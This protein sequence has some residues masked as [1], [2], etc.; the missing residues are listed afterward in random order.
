V[1]WKISYVDNG[2]AA[3]WATDGAPASAEEVWRR[4]GGGDA[5]RVGRLMPWLKRRKKECS[6]EEI[7]KRKNRHEGDF[8][9]VLEARTGVEPV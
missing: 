2:G 9:C 6:K 8:F 4:D 5:A 3:V 7:Q 1:I